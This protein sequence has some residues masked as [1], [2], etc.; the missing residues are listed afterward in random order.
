MEMHPVCNKHHSNHQEK[1]KRKHFYCRVFIY[2]FADGTGKLYH[3]Y[4]S[5]DDCHNH[6]D[7]IAHQT[8]GGE[9]AVER[10]YN[11]NEHDLKNCFSKI[12]RAVGYVL[13]VF[14]SFYFFVNL[15]RCAD[16]QKNSSAKKN[17]VADR[18][19]VKFQCIRNLKG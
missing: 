9:N 17:D 15:F 18:A 13:R 6:D 3:R 10:K 16:E 1:C 12:P 5:H 4:H 7:N 2:D 19:A 8:D 11:I 14:H